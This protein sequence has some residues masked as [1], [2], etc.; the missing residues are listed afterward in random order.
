[1]EWDMASA[2][3]VMTGWNWETTGA[4]SIDGTTLRASGNAGARV[5]GD[6][7]VDMPFAT[8]PMLHTWTAQRRK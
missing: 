8:P 5:S 6:L 3:M 2:G 4:L 1:M 7:I